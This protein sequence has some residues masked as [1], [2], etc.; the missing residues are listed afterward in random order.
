MYGYI[1]V[2][3]LNGLLLFFQRSQLV[4]LDGEESGSCPVQSSVPQG[5]VLGPCLSLI[6]INCVFCSNRIRT[7]V[8]MQLIVAID[9]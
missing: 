4:V 5:S 2:Q 3:S 9:L 7:L 8:A 1:I 6:Y